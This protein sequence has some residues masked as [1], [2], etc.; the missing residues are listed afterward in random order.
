MVKGLFYFSIIIIV[1]Y[2]WLQQNINNIH[3]VWIV[4]CISNKNEFKQKPMQYRTASYYVHSEKTMIYPLIYYH[5][6]QEKELHWRRYLQIY[7]IGTIKYPREPSYIKNLFIKCLE[8]NLWLLVIYKIFN[9]VKSK[10]LYGF[11]KGF[12]VHVYLSETNAEWTNFE[13]TKMFSKKIL[14]TLYVQTLKI[15]SKHRLS[16]I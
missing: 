4:L 7:K 9:Q 1:L 15:L 5:Q 10:D 6:L 12:L 8:V 14:A 2:L 13:W 16:K 3:T 11:E